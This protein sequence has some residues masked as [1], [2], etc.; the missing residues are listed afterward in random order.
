[1]WS[2]VDIWVLYF[3]LIVIA[4][5]VTRAVGKLSDI[6]FWLLEDPEDGNDD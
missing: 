4:I 3:L 1:M 2:D 5:Q 6:L